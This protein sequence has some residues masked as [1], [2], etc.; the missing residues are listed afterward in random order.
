MLLLRDRGAEVV[1]LDLSAGMLRTAGLAGVV[2]ADMRRLPVRTGVLDGV[3][4]QA[5]LLHVPRADVPA[6]LAEFRR[7]LAPT[8]LLHLVVSEGEGQGWEAHRYGSALPRWFVHHS[9]EKLRELLNT[10]GFDVLDVRRLV[11]ERNWLRLRAASS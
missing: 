4:S 10:A 2:Q 11:A 1:G 9:E 7:V 5:A 8:G 6:A 3:W